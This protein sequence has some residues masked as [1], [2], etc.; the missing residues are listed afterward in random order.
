LE[1]IFEFYNLYRR[2]ILLSLTLILTGILCFSGIYFFGTMKT[3]ADS[4][5]SQLESEE[6]IIQ[7]ETEEKKETI[8]EDIE[9][10]KVDIK[11]LVK[12]PG[13]YELSIGSRVKDVISKSGGL[14]KNADTSVINLSKKITDEMVIIIYSKEQVK[15]FA[16]TIEEE[17]KVMQ[18]C[19]ENSGLVK[20]DACVNKN[21]NND[22]KHS[23]TDEV[24]VNINT[25]NLEQLLTLTGI[26]E[27]KAKAIIAYRDE[28]GKFEKV[29]DIKN[30]SGIGDAL[31]EKIKNNI[32]V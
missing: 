1:K 10:Y 28:V 6:L 4:I 21:E 16:K 5:S 17:N 22:D 20:N 3:K 23:G 29:E 2:R 13:V 26:G 27:S 30:V 19:V 7:E 25:A 31:F 12:N 8:E 24:L 18:S 11:G 9:K 15:D 14:L 32:T